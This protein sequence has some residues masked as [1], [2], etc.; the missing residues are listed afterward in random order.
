M[1][2]DLDHVFLSK[3]FWF[4]EYGHQHFVYDL[5]FI[6][7][8]GPEMNGMRICLFKVFSPEYLVGYTD[9]LRAGKTDHCN[10]TNP[11]RS[12]QSNDGVVYWACILQWT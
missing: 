12:S 3:G 7:S 9:C 6:S 5:P 11:L 4:P 10:G 2:G 8:D 1:T